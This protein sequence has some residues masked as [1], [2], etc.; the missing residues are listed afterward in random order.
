MFGTEFLRNAILIF[1]SFS[2]SES[3]AY[4][5]ERGLEMNEGKVRDAYKLHFQSAF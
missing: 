2:Y 1:T 5:R 4:R 3:S